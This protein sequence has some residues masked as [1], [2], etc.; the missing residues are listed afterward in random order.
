M[1]Y[2]KYG[3][4]RTVKVK[5]YKRGKQGRKSGRYT[6]K[7]KV[8]S[9]KRTVLNWG[10]AKGLSLRPVIKYARRPEVNFRTTISDIPKGFTVPPKFY[11]YFGKDPIKAENKF[12]EAYNLI[13]QIVKEGIMKGIELF[14][15]NFMMKV[16]S[17]TGNLRKALIRSISYYKNRFPT[18]VKWGAPRVKYASV[19]NN[20][21][22][23][24]TQVAH[25]PGVQMSGVGIP[26]KYNA[27]TGDPK[28]VHHFFDKGSIDL[29]NS[30]KIS[31]RHT[32]N[33]YNMPISIFKWMVKVT[34]VRI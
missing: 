31:M 17:K 16:P 29:Q 6:K 15:D 13:P 2:R 3:Q 28:A 26:H 25:R 19:I 8:K 27:G 18:T 33:R 9:Y 21:T 5:G 12:V 4:S 23:T 10:P 24:S 1:S 22:P 20:M 7:K 14:V 32:I 34:E 11:A 30:I